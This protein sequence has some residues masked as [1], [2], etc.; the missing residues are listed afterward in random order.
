MLTISKWFW[1]WLFVLIGILAIWK[2]AVEPV[3]PV[4]TDMQYH[5]HRVFEGTK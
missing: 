3:L 4:I 1:T 2:C 5:Y